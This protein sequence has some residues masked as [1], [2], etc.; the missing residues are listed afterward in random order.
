MVAIAE[1]KALLGMDSSKFKAGARDAKNQVTSLQKTLQAA[2]RQMAAAFSVGAILAF[3]RKMMTLADDLQ[4]AANTVGITMESMLGLKSAMAESGIGADAMLRIMGK[5]KNAQGEVVEGNITFTD[6]LKKLNISEKEFVALDVDKLLEFMANKYMD[7]GESAE[8]FNAI[9]SIFGERIGPQLIEVLQRLNQDGLQQYI[10]ES[11]KAAEGMRDLAEA[12]DV[13][14]SAMN[15]VAI[16]F[17]NIITWS[18]QLWSLNNALLKTYVGLAGVIPRF[19]RG[20]KFGKG[21]S[22][23][24]GDAW[25]H[26]TKPWKDRENDFLAPTS[27]ELKAQQQRKQSAS[28]SGSNVKALQDR[29]E[30]EAAEAVAKVRTKGGK[31]D[32]INADSVAKIGGSIG[33]ARAGLGLMDRNTMIQTDQ[34]K[35]Q[36]RIEQLLQNIAARDARKDGG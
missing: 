34:L 11:S 17:A 28:Q 5:L 30:R 22:K 16:G 19:V 8:A 15:K 33:G 7:A 35:I 26:V 9:T 23:A 2:G 21:I 12:N 20:V 36:Q 14:E 10:D 1:L 24:A 27:G 4:T 32:G 6:A 3:S 31:V 18:K 13:L 29:K 25:G